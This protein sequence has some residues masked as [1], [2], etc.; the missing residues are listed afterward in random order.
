MQHLE[1]IADVVT[2]H[3]IIR[4]KLADVL[5][6]KAAEREACQRGTGRIMHQG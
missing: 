6:A 5:A 2:L 1:T 3:A 4:L